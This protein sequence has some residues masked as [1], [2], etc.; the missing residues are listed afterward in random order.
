MSTNS[1]ERLSNRKSRVPSQMDQS[2]DLS[3]ISNIIRSWRPKS[4]A[5]SQSDDFSDA[6]VEVNEAT[7]KLSKELN[8]PPSD[9]FLDMAILGKALVSKAAIL[10]AQLIQF[11]A[12]ANKLEG[13]IEKLCLL[14][15]EYTKPEQ[16]TPVF[17][18]H[19]L[20]LYGEITDSLELLEKQNPKIE[21]LNNL[22]TIISTKLGNHELKS[23]A[24][25]R[26]S[27]DNYRDSTSSIVIMFN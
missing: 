20:E 10:D 16:L 18:M 5:S 8:L 11:L 17:K 23:V 9:L 19:I 15:S 27:G 24:S 26:R 13:K 6:I 3:A 12:N 25:I 2:N 1:E 22:K 14:L 4:W 21:K 7:E